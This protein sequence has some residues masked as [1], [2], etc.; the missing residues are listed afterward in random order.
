[1]PVLTM[2]QEVFNKILT[3]SEKFVAIVNN[4]A[5]FVPAPFEALSAKQIRD[6]YN[7]NLASSAV[8]VNKF[9]PV[10]RKNKGIDHSPIS[11]KMLKVEW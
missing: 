8:M 11:N 7:T 9:L 2:L 10:L 3:P 5:I 4:A 6:N 1:M